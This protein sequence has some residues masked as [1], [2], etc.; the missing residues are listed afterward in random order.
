MALR[1][2]ELKGHHADFGAESPIGQAASR[3]KEHY[4]WAINRAR[5]RREVEKT[6]LK[7]EKYVASRLVKANLDSSQPL[8]VATGE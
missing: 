7:V 4:G 2:W 6:P 1:V 8:F 3:F 5:V